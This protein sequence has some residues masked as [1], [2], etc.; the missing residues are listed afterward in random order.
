MQILVN[1]VLP[2]FLVSGGV[3]LLQS[4]LRLSGDAVA[5]IGL[6][7]FV[8]A[9]TLRALLEAEGAI[10]EMLRVT[11]AVIIVLVILLALSELASRWLHLGRPQRGALVSSV[12]LGNAGAF[13]LPVLVFVF[14]D[15][16]FLPGMFHVILFN[17]L[18]L[19]LVSIYLAALQQAS[20]GSALQRV[21]RTPVVYAAVV[22]TL[23]R[24][25]GVT[26][27]EPLLRAI[28]L[29]A[30]GAIP[31]MLVLLGVQLAETFEGGL[32]LNRAPALGVLVALRLA[33][34]PLAALGAAALLG[35]EGV[36]RVAL[37]INAGMST[38]ILAGA[39]ARDYAADMP[40][41]TLG[42]LTTTILSLGTTTLW[43]NWLL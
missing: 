11:L 34:A 15:A 6:L 43:L 17:V 10:G 32:H 25:S 31:L 2:V 12:V 21:A 29:I 38:A 18:L 4:R 39:L 8:P 13:A 35:I 37:V 5:Q 9:L 3:A 24:L 36:A 41:A 7:I 19:P 33:I 20:L 16:A 26:V 22:G 40:L 28:A 14:G 1:V 27:P 30:D 42:V 23:I